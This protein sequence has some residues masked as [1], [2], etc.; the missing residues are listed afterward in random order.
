M[1]S[2]SW[3]LPPVASDPPKAP[4][5]YGKRERATMILKI[6]DVIAA[7]KPKEAGP[8]KPGEKKEEES[9]SEID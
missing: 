2:L 5:A 9:S 4:Q 6:D 1:W 7:G 3:P 8:P